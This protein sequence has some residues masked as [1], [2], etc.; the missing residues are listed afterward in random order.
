MADAADPEA[1]D[2]AETAYGFIERYAPAQQDAEAKWDEAFRQAKE[3][4]K[5]VWVRTSQRYCGPCFRLSRWIDDHREVIEK[6]FV[7]LKIDDVRDLNGQAVA[8]RLTKG[9][10][11]GV[12]FHA[13]FDASETL[14]A[15][16]F[17]PLGNIGSMS[18]VEG[19][20][21]FKKMLDGAC[22]KITSQEI[23]MLLDSLGD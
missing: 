10:V 16:S 19:K 9:R 3:Q 2:A 17:G 1:V 6:D 12:P 15:D 13:M 14:I 7:V 8:G 20:R 11:V 5:R 18:G 4:N 23:Q 21:H 22:S